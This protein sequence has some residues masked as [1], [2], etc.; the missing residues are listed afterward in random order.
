MTT[1]TVSTFINT[2]TTEVHSLHADIFEQLGSPE[3]ITVTVEAGDLL[4]VAEDIVETADE[5]EK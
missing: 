2:D 3:E 5:A 1:D 4:N